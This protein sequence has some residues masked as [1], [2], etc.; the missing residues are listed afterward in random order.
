MAFGMSDLLFERQPPHVFASPY[1]S[2]Y[3]S[4]P[5]PWNF[6][7]SS[8]PLFGD[9][10]R[11]DDGYDSPAGNL[12]QRRRNDTRKHE[13]ARK[14]AA[15]SRGPQQDLSEPK[16]RQQ[17]TQE[18]AV[19]RKIPVQRPASNDGSTRP[20]RPTASPMAGVTGVPA[21]KVAPVSVLTPDNAARKVQAA[22]RGYSVRQGKPLELARSIADVRTLVNEMDAQL[23]DNGFAAKMV[24][25]PME[26]LRVSETIMS[27][28]L[29]LDEVQSPNQDVRNLR[30]DMARKL[31][32]LL[33]RVDI[34]SS[35]QP[36]EA[37]APLEVDVDAGVSTM[38]D[39]GMDADPPFAASMARLLTLSL[40]ALS[41][42]LLLAS[43]AVATRV[44]PSS[45]SPRAP[46]FATN[47]RRQ[48]FSRFSCGRSNLKGY[49][50]KAGLTNGLVLHWKAT[51]GRTIKMA[52][53]ASG[54]K[55]AGW[56]SVGFSPNGGMA[57]SNAIATDSS[58]SPVTKDLVGQS[59]AD[60]ASWTVGSG[61]I[62]TSGSKVIMKFTKNKGDGASVKVKA[63]NDNNIVWAFGDGDTVSVHNGAGKVSVNFACGCPWFQSKC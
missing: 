34:L 26:K 36:H 10:F 3:H 1:A 48:L 16:I 42:V 46:S 40:L 61:S 14:Q 30:R 45:Q 33:D 51:K 60:D 2:H 19:L 24:S 17:H 38:D 62:S 56:F 23:R 6:A 59:S 47:S 5:T 21:A 55:A 49:T 44:A 50:S 52:V 41:C 27:W 7:S 39:A 54:A 43:Q 35:T 8:S 18:Q 12:A 37:E 57:G 22:W 31:T 29:R 4:Q 32:K 11:F 15:R 25:E 28:L 20:D 53:V 13:I 63:D 58:G 9:P